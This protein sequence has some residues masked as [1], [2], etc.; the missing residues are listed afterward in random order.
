MKKFIALALALILTLS[1]A[2]VAFAADINADNG[3]DFATVTGT[4]NLDIIGAE[5]ITVT[6]DW[7]N[8]GYTYTVTQ[9][10]QPASQTYAYEGAWAG[11]ATTVTITNKSVKTVYATVAVDENATILEYVDFTIEG[12]EANVELATSDDHVVSVSIAQNDAKEGAALLLADVDDGATFDIATVTVTIKTT[13][14][15]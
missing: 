2:V 14:L 9:T 5:D 8:P 15:Q 13:A 3:N 11:E 1:M 4:Y 6:V 7:T 12:E 10:W